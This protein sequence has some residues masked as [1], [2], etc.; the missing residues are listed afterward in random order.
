MPPPGLS[1]QLSDREQV[2]NEAKPDGVK[3]QVET[4]IKRSPEQERLRRSA[5]LKMQEIKQK[6]KEKE[7]E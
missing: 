1:F 6:Q 2:R 4:K 5:Y 7:K 3:A